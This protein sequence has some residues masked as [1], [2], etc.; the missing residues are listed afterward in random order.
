M[1]KGGES[2][3]ETVKENIQEH[4]P[5]NDGMETGE[6][7]DRDT[8][9]DFE[10]LHHFES[11]FEP[12]MVDQLSS[13][14]CYGRGKALADIFVPRLPKKFQDENYDVADHGS[15]D[16]SI[17]WHTSYSG[18]IKKKK[19]KGRRRRETLEK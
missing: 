11:Q 8:R 12:N 4:N 14:C 9:L 7:F 15:L 19:I 2:Q 13:S 16:V 18:H 5:P 3:E 1:A 6:I 10:T 17:L